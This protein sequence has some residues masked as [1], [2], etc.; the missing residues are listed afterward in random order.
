[1]RVETP[2]EQ[3]LF[4]T[5]RIETTTKQGTA[6]GTAFIYNHIIEGERNALFLVTNKHVIEGA[7]H[8]KFF[9][10]EAEGGKPKIGARFDI[11]AEDFESHWFGHSDPDVDLA[12]LPL[13]PVL[14]Q[15]EAIGKSV[16]FK[17]IPSNIIPTLDQIEQLD[18][19]EEVII[20]G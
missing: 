15:I 5:V 1:M 11:D 6:T 19:L 10:T 14:K 8:G 9:F 20:F 13:V 12:V 7:G 16:F 18:A 4:S 17:A 3:L 2:S